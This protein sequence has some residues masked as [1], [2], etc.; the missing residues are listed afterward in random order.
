[1]PNPPE[2]PEITGTAGFELEVSWSAPATGFYD[3]YLLRYAPIGETDYEE[4][5]VLASDTASYMLTG[6]D[7][8]TSYDISIV[9]VQGEGMSEPAQVY[10]TTGNVM[11]MYLL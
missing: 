8:E 3:Y 4:V 6:L 10:G 11:V 1:M 7:P 9:T 5:Q 2:D